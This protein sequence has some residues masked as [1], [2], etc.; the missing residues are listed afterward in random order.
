[1]TLLGCFWKLME[2]MTINELIAD[3]VVALAIAISLVFIVII[4]MIAILAI[5]IQHLY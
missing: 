1:L 3:I 5:A 2:E 4:T